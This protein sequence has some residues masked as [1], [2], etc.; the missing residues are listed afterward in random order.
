MDFWLEKPA[1][2]LT[3]PFFQNLLPPPPT[4]LQLITHLRA[5]KAGNIVVVYLSSSFVEKVGFHPKSKQNLQNKNKD[6]RTKIFC[7][8]ITE[9]KLR[10]KQQNHKILSYHLFSVSCGSWVF[11]FRTGCTSSAIRAGTPT[12]RWQRHLDGWYVSRQAT[13]VESGSH[14]WTKYSKSNRTF[15]DEPQ[16]QKTAV[17]PNSNQGLKV[18]LTASAQLNP[19]LNPA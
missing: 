14:F 15:D 18:K 6:D 9:K 11:C 19:I 16:L 12:Y 4:P 7:Q 3:P 8:K 5:A 10:K 17:F 2:H 13:S 1:C